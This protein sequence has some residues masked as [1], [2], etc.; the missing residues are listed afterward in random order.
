MQM[1][2][3]DNRASKARVIE[4]GLNHEANAQMAETDNRASKTRV[5]ETAV[6]A[7]SRDTWSKTSRVLDQKLLPFD[8]RVFKCNATSYTL[9]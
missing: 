1:A 8:F 9:L 5:V 7:F 4:T 2:E 3:N 6:D